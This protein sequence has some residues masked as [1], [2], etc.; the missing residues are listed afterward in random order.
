M[1]TTQKNP[2]KR[3]KTT[4]DYRVE[5]LYGYGPV[6]VPAGSTVTNKTAVDNDDSY[7]FW[8]DFNKVAEEVSGYKDSLLHHDLRYYGLNIPKEYCEPYEEG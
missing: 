1:K 2:V 7:H 6:T 4:T 8:V 3:A 5:N